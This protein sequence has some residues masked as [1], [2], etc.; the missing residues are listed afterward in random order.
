MKMRQMKRRPLPSFIILE[1]TS[2]GVLSGVFSNIASGQT[3]I[4]TDGTASFLVTI[5]SGV[6]GDVVLSD[7]QAVPEPGMLG[8]LGLGGIMLMRRRRV[9]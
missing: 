1:T 3:L 6:D 8:V 7:F 2:A 5:N 4:T 9:R